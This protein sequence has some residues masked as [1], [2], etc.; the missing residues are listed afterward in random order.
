MTEKPSP[1]VRRAVGNDAQ[2]VDARRE[3][4]V[5]NGLGG[6]ASATIADTITRRYHGFLN[7]ALPEPLGRM[8]QAAAE[9][10]DQ[11]SIA[12]SACRRCRA[13]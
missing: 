1:E 12:Q 8:H 2:G 10:P 9:A 7:A 11:F 6:Y 4:L 3:W 5:A 13:I